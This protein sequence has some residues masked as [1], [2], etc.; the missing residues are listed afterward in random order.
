MPEDKSDIPAELEP[1]VATAEWE[2]D[3]EVTARTEV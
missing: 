1:E 3:G 2:R